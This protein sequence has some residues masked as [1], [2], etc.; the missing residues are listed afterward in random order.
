MKNLIVFILFS[1]PWIA[2]GQTENCHLKREKDGIKVY[3][4]KTDGE[5]FRMVRAEFV[6]E[7]TSIEK[8][9]KFLWDVDNYVSWQYRALAA[10]QLTKPDNDEMTYRVE[11]NAP[12][13]VENRE[14]ILRFKIIRDH[15]PERMDIDIQTIEWA[16][17]PP[18]GMVRVPFSKATWQIWRDGRSL[19]VDYWLQI[20]PGGYVPPLLVNLALA[21]GPYET[22]KKLKDQIA[23]RK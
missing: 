20:D 7:N 6:L 16:Q 15:L 19:K 23:L 17:P 14:L 5:R 4:C 10:Q 18:H 3:T 22:F 21:D 9:E 8:L 12:W 1:F 2:I 13:P 11:V